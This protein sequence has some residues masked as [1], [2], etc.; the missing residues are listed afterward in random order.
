MAASR[1]VRPERCPLKNDEIRHPDAVVVVN[2]GKM[3]KK[4]GLKVKGGG[5]KTW[6]AYCTSDDEKYKYN[7]VGSFKL[8]QKDVLMI[9]APARSATTFYSKGVN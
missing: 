8:D 3:E 4:V 7:A 6:E 5:G 2:I 9:D 1:R